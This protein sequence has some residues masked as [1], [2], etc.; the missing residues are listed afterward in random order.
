MVVNKVILE[1]KMSVIMI[2][3]VYR[4]HVVVVI[5]MVETKDNKIGEKDSLQTIEMGLGSEVV[6]VE[7]IEK[8]NVVPIK[9][10]VERM[11]GVKVTIMTEEMEGIVEIRTVEHN[12]L[13]IAIPLD[14]IMLN[15][16]SGIIITL[17]VVKDTKTELTR[18]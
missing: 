6:L 3:K 10:Q 14:L 1:V 13:M 18:M 2:V 11:K 16:M 4:S 7:T 9:E 15:G 12:D 5:D 17:V 8:M